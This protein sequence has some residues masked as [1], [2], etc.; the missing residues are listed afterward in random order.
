MLVV[1]DDLVEPTELA[2]YFVS[3]AGEHILGVLEEAEIIT[4]G[5]LTAEV[6]EDGC[7]CAGSVRVDEVA[8]VLLTRLLGLLRH[9]DAPFDD[10][11][12]D[13]RSLTED[14]AREEA[15]RLRLLL[16]FQVVLRIF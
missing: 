5:V 15:N 4:E 3:I 13:R 14:L 7:P 16:L 2:E 1:S 10:P 9:L 6:E 8:A 11:L 12:H